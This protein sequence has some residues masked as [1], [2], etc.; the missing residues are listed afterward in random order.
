MTLGPLCRQ[1]PVAPAGNA[2]L[3]RRSL[4]RRIRRVRD[5]K[6]AR[7]NPNPRSE[8]A[9]QQGPLQDSRASVL[10]DRIAFARTCGPPVGRL[11][12]LGLPMLGA[13]VIAALVAA[14][15]HGGG[16][17]QAIAMHGD[18]GRP[19]DFS[20]FAYANPGAPKGGRLTQA[21]VGT[22]DSLNPFIIK[23]QPFDQVRGSAIE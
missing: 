17:V 19:V 22:F 2:P 12:R 21:I 14:R 6:R 10:R 3:F 20:H 7:D 1:A 23:G 4:R 11:S 18:A 9:L 13:V 8:E 15:A 5:R 16:A